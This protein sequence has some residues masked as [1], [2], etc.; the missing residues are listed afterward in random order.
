MSSFFVLC[1]GVDRFT[2]TQVYTATGLL[3]MRCPDKGNVKEWKRDIRRSHPR[4]FVAT[5]H[6]RQL[7]FLLK[8]HVP[9]LRDV[10]T[11]IDF[12]SLAVISILKME[13]TRSS[14]TSAFFKTHTAPHSRRRH[15]SWSPL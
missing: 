9:F 12:S 4:I 15:S 3:A 11:L 10:F 14:E 8:L 13:A 7:R 1:D 6:A 5:S 2:S